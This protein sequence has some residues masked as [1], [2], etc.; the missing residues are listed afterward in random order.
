MGYDEHK[1]RKKEKKRRKEKKERKEKLKS[2]EKFS[3]K[4]FKKAFKEELEPSS[5]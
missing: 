2:I 3:A 1:R 5:K 4:V